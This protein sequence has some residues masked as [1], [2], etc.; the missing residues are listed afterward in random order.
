MYLR[1]EYGSHIAKA[2]EALNEA[3]ARTGLTSTGLTSD[4]VVSLLNSGLEV[5]DLLAYM[6]AVLL[7]R[8]H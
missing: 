8:V 4:D 5:P 7:N 1:E 6:D 3:A 2:V